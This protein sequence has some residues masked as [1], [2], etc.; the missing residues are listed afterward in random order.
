MYSLDD[1]VKNDKGGG[2]G[3]GVFQPNTNVRFMQLKNQPSLLFKILPAYDPSTLQFNEG[4]YTPTDRKTWT[5]FRDPQTHQLQVFARKIKVAGFIGHGRGK[6]G[7]RRDLLSPLTFASGNED[8]ETYCPLTE[9]FRAAENDARWDYLVKD[10]LGPDGK[11]PIERQSLS[12]PGIQLLVNIVDVNNTQPKVE[13]GVFTSSAYKS[14]LSRD[15]PVGLAWQTANISDPAYLAQ[16]PMMRWATGDLTDPV[17]GPVLT[18]SKGDGQYG[19][20]N[21][22]MAKDASGNVIR[23]PI[24]D[25]LLEQRYNLL[26]LESVVKRQSEEDLIRQLVKL[27]NGVSPTS[28]EHEWVL[29]KQVFGNMVG[30][31]V[32]PDPPA[33]GYTQGFTAPVPQQ[34]PGFQ[35]PIQGGMPQQQPGFQQPAQGAMPQPG[36]MQQPPQQQ[37][38]GSLL[39]SGMPPVAPPGAVPMTPPA[40]TPPGPT[41]DNPSGFPGAVPPAA[42]GPPPAAGPEQSLIN[43]ASAGA[44]GSP[45]ADQAPP[46][47]PP[48]AQAQEGSA[49]VPGDQPPGFQPEGFMDRLRELG[50]GGQAQGG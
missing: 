31:D 4:V 30:S 34:Q 14:L 25:Y 41:M 33:Q 19:R 46:Q 18:M 7:R 13:L 22:H 35:P 27:L 28:G 37:Q 44:Q 40:T 43:Q 8:G 3:I 45:G 29:L 1:D 23:V 50:A 26:H 39:G 15:N 49:P 20:Y 9:L 5:P 2:H 10:K 12:F 42:P 6:D 32:I 48:A 38:P 21:I 36:Q 47:A 24:P 11:T 17:N 16:N